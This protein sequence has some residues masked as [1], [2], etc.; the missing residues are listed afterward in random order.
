[1]L[2]EKAILER[3]R[4]RE[5]LF[6]A[7]VTKRA[8]FAELLIYVEDNLLDLREL[9]KLRGTNFQHAAEKYIEHVVEQWQQ[10]IC[11]RANDPTVAADKLRELLIKIL[12]AL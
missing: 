7:N 12:K 6:L 5:K 3:A 10:H 11:T 4:E 1:M 2:T 8:N 9:T